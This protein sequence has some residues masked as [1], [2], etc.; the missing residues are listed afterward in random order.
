MIDN[1]IMEEDRKEKGSDPG[2]AL[3]ST[4]LRW[5]VNCSSRPHG[6]CAKLGIHSPAPLRCSPSPWIWMLEPAEN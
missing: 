5:S 4:A 3:A 1:K 6:S 2:T